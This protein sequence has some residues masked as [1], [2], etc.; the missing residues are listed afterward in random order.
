MMRARVA[1]FFERPANGQT[2]SFNF[3]FHRG[4]STPHQAATGSKRCIR[5]STPDNALAVSS[6]SQS[7]R[8]PSQKPLVVPKNAARRRTVTHSLFE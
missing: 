3:V 8:K 5:A 1:L 4:H 7:A 6:V 2:D